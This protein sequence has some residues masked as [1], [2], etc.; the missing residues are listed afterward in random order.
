MTAFWIVV[1][2]VFLCFTQVGWLLLRAGIV[3]ALIACALYATFWI[4]AA[5]V[6]GLMGG[7]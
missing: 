5:V 1:L 7:L 4:A 2:I 3:A 6:V